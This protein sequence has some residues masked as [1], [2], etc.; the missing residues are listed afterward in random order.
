MTVYLA[1]KTSALR[2]LRRVR[3]RLRRSG[4]RV[5]SG[6]LDSAYD[7]GDPRCT[8]EHLRSEAPRDRVEVRRCGLFIL[9]TIDESTSGGRDVELGMALA[10]GK[11][12]WLVGPRRN[13][14]HH[15]AARHFADWRACARALRAR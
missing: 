2:R 10:H 6:W 4:L 11:R 1:G 5:S 7:Y 9:D 14:F 3:A 15:L 12:F 8:P 13:V